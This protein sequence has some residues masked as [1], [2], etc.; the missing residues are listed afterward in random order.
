MRTYHCKNKLSPIKY[1]MGAVYSGCF[2]L[3]AAGLY[4]SLSMELFTW[5]HPD[6]LVAHSSYQ[7]RGVLGCTSYYYT[8]TTINRLGAALAVCSMA[9]IADWIGTPYL[10]WAILRSAMYALIPLSLAIF[11]HKCLWISRSL[12]GISALL[13]TSAVFFII[14][15]PD[16]FIFGLDIAI[17][18]TFTVTFYLLITYY[19]RGIEQKK[20]FVGFCILY[21]LHLTSHEIALVLG[22][23]FLPLYIWE[24]HGQAFNMQALFTMFKKTF[25]DRHVQVLTAIYISCALLTL[26]APGVKIRQSIWPSTSTMSD[27]LLFLGQAC[28]ECAYILSQAYPL[29]LALC[30]L[31]ICVQLL[32]LRRAQFAP[33]KKLLLA[34]VF[35]A[36]LAYLLITAF[37]LGTTPSLW[38]GSMR[39]QSFNLLEALLPGHANILGQGA[40][41]IR[42]NIPLYVGFC[43]DAFLLG[44]LGAKRVFSARIAKFVLL[45]CAL[46]IMN[47]ICAALFLFHPDAANSVQLLKAL[48][49][50]E[51]TKKPVASRSVA[52]ELFSAGNGSSA[53]LY[54]RT[55][56]PHYE[57]P[58][59]TLAIDR[60]LRHSHYVKEGVLNP[61]YALM[62][63]GYDVSNVPGYINQ[64]YGLYDIVPTQPCQS[65]LGVSNKTATCYTL[66]AEN[67]GL[68]I[69]HT[70]SLGPSIPIVLADMQGMTK[71]ESIGNCPLLRETATKGEHFIA[72][73]I[74]LTKGLHYFFFDTKSSAIQTYI[75]LLGKNTLL[76][77]FLNLQNATIAKPVASDSLRFV[78]KQMQDLGETQRLALVVN[79]SEAQTITLRWEHAKGGS[80]IYGGRTGRISALCGVWHG[81]LTA[82]KNL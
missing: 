45:T 79:A 67:E 38:A 46:I 65:I 49:V 7:L 73:K 72:Q 42:Q 57:I 33:K 6:E 30:A 35:I 41:G 21:A 81:Q 5:V 32:N 61:I 3:A 14:A 4:F 50:G 25:N 77:P 64:I 71:E 82:K 19:S 43:V 18:V 62:G 74:F 26:L 10:G 29:L 1:L 60:E 31:G 22:A 52:Q 68:K 70:K 48:T 9:N 55:W 47:I 13:I 66:A 44:F 8:D 34:Y 36:P 20:R 24:R 37:L 51:N 78:F 23:F 40:F 76:I 2:F 56:N 12:S 59:V 63:T 75:F 11:F 15:T 80:T 27:S 54:Q 53:M 16:N 58:L 69:L 39:T 28:E 17:Y